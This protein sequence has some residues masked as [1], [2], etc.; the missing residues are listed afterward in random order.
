[1]IDF[2]EDPLRAS[3]N[4]VRKC[5]LS[6]VREVLNIKSQENPNNSTEMALCEFSSSRLQSAYLP[7]CLGMASIDFPLLP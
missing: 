3:Q 4:K 5:L 1:M 6:C 7:F 2:L